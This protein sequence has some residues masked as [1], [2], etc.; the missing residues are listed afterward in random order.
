MIGDDVFLESSQMRVAGPNWELLDLSDIDVLLISNFYNMAALPFLTEYT[1][2]NGAVYATEPTMQIGRSF[3][4]E[5]LILLES[6]TEQLNF[7]TQNS[8]HLWQQTSVLS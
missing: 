5:L 4:M 6:Q 8:P 3:L 1:N 2:F 7:V